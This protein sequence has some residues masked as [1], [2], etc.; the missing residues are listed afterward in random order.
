MANTNPI[1]VLI[2]SGEGTSAASISQTIHSL[3]ASLSPLY[4]VSTIS[5]PALLNEPW[6][7]SCAALV[8]PGG[9]DLPYCRLLNGRGNAR[10]RL[11]VENGGKY[12]GF[13]AGGYYA[14]R[15][16]EF[17]MGHEGMEVVGERELGFFPGAK[18]GLAF[19]G[20]E[21]QTEKGARAAKLSVNRKAL[22]EVKDLKD[23]VLSYYN[24]G[25]VFI[26]AASYKE[27]GIEILASYAEN[28][29]CESDASKAAVVY[30][31][32]GNGA[33]LLTGPHPEYV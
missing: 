16:C 2:Y 11:F 33:A 29:D 21:Y 5:S 26:D 18:R 31:K 25:G 10:I 20:F 17:M 8:M 28:L 12:L 24:G 14:S 13:C 7:A 32:V 3:R 23:E 22:G 9:A 30:C 19:R 15:R 4:V 27:D 6:P 1:N